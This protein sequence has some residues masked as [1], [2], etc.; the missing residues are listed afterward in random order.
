MKSNGVVEMVQRGNSESALKELKKEGKLLC[1]LSINLNSHMTH[2]ARI[3]PFFRRPWFASGSAVIGSTVTISQCLFKSPYF[4]FK[5]QDVDNLELSKHFLFFS[6]F[7]LQDGVVVV[8]CLESIHILRKPKQRQNRRE[9]KRS[10]E[11]LFRI[12]Y[13]S[14]QILECMLKALNCVLQFSCHST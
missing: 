1:L 12:D 8:F 2:L 5:V 7:A 3:I 14:L 6:L 11:W 9:D 13:A 4:T 10:M